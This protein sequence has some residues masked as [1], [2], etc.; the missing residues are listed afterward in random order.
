MKS[1]SPLPAWILSERNSLM[2]AGDSTE[3]FH[4]PHPSPPY[5][6]IPISSN[7][8]LDDFQ[9]LQS[10]MYRRRVDLMDDENYDGKYDVHKT[11]SPGDQANIVD[12]KST[13]HYPV[14]VHQPLWYAPPMP[15]TIA[16]SMIRT[17]EE[18][19]DEEDREDYDWSVDRDLNEQ[20]V[21]FEKQMGINCKPQ[22][23]GFTRCILYQLVGV[24]HCFAWQ[25]YSS[26]LAMR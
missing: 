20:Q 3:D 19:K 17:D 6:T 8:V 9:G 4:D 7:I 10:P 2:A 13:V 15:N 12:A 25:G 23:W 16:P 21:K 11:E 14:D 26:L 22:G 18:H 24:G 1:K 5:R